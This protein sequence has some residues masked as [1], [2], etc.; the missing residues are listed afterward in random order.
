EKNRPAT[1][2]HPLWSLIAD[3]RMFFF[4]MTGRL[5]TELHRHGIK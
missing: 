4:F 2:R 5:G 3:F 1:F